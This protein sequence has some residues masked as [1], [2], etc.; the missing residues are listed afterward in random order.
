MSKQIELTEVTGMMMEI[1]KRIDNATREIFKL[2]KNKATTEHIYREAL[3]K[4]IAKLRIEGVQAT[5]IPDLARG[6]TAY[7]KYERD[8]ARDVYNSAK[9]SLE[10]LQVEVSVLQTIIKYQEVI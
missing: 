3:S 2:A 1:S 10:A 8:L 7:L 4:E 6:N 5:L 9:S